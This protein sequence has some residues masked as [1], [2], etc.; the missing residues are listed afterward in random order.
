VKV[1]AVSNSQAGLMTTALTNPLTGIYS[2][3]LPQGAYSFTF[4]SDNALSL[5]K[6]HELPVNYGSD[7]IRIEPVILQE[8]D[9][10]AYLRLLSDTL[11]KVSSPEPVS[12]S[13]IAE[14][15][16]ILV[17]EVLSSDSVLIT[18]RYTISDS[19]FTFTFLPEKG[20]NEINF[21]L[22][23]RFGNDT[24]TVVRVS[25]RDAATV[26]T[27]PLYREIP[28]RPAV[29]KAAEKAAEKPVDKPITTQEKATA[30]EPGGDSMTPVTDETAGK[31]RC[32]WW[33]LLMAASLIILF[34]LWIRRKRK[35]NDK[36]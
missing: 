22:T 30:G 24:S 10:S 5:S 32:H 14:E 34:L 26:A 6:S 33:W 9:F 18:E 20:E 31:G 16:S 15:K 28:V 21:S 29:E 1:T 8:T 11:I 3:K 35:K 2:F 12:I 19:S 27:R 25:R 17:A 7:T 13:L 23:D 4:D 36:D